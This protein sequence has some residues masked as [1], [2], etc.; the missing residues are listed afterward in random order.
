MSTTKPWL[1]LTKPVSEC[2]ICSNH[3]FSLWECEGYIFKILLP[4]RGCQ[5]PTQF[6]LLVQSLA[7]SCD[8]IGDCT[9][10]T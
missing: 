6:A 3:Q 8:N 1:F 2:A 9:H 5:A 4:S 10:I 7:T